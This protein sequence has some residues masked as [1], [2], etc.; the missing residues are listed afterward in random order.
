MVETSQILF[1][2]N[3][4]CHSLGITANELN[5]SLFLSISTDARRH[6]RGN[7]NFEGSYILNFEYYFSFADLLFVEL[8]KAY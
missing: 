2:N 8:K 6:S 5:Y 4:K 1:E 3:P 7:L